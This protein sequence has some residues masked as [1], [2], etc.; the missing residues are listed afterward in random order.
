MRNRDAT[1]V[2]DYMSLGDF[3]ACET[4]VLLV[5]EAH[6]PPHGEFL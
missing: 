5:E 3:W 6:I 1:D 4:S 2:T